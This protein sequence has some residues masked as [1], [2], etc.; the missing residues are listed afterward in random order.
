MS[1]TMYTK[2]QWR[3][4]GRPF[5][6]GRSGNPA[7]RRPGSRNKATL[8][9]ELYLDGEAEEVCRSAVAQARAGNDKRWGRYPNPTV[10][11][12]L[13]QLRRLVNGLIRE[14]GPPD[15]IAVEMT[16]DFKLSPLQLSKL[17]KEQAENQQKNEARRA[18][19]RKLGQAENARN[20]LKLRLWE[21]LNL[22]DPLDRRCPFSGE[23]ISV[24]RLL[25][26]EVEI[27]H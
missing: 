12:G 2:P 14:Y 25:S 8:A 11:I 10:H 9:A 26:D 21:E 4:R 1:E 16:R 18:E 6:K 13:G 24:A 17:E 3:G 27:E 19:L 7:G 20:V 15:E 5:P 22:R 23:V